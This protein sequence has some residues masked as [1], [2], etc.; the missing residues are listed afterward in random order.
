MRRSELE[1]FYNLIEAFEK[2]PGVGKK[3]A[4]RFAYFIVSDGKFEGLKLSH[5]I[6]EAISKIRSCSR[7]HNLS[8]D[9][10]C[11]ICSDPSRDRSKV[12][13]VNSVKDLLA[14]EESK[15]YDGLY[16]VIR[17]IEDLD[18]SHLKEALKDAKEVIFAF[19][20]SIAS[21]TMILYIESQLEDMDITFSKIAQGVP[22]GVSLDNIDTLSIAK[23]I[24][25]RVRV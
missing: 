6:E 25:D 24:E 19:P 10:L 2:L 8:E 16:Y 9:E 20:P 4:L 23:A 3:S 1:S 11:Y 13:M 18:I 14:I 21:D 12:C 17:D 5:A 7:C 15:E 22:T